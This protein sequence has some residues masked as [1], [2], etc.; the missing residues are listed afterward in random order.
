MGFIN[1][2]VNQGLKVWV[3][4][5]L[6]YKKEYLTNEYETTK[7]KNEKSCDVDNDLLTNYKEKVFDRIYYITET[8]N[9]II[10]SIF[11]CNHKFLDEK[12]INEFDNN[13]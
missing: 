11:K 6:K 12:L 10:K 1:S 3:F 5:N 13:L 8:H 7:I 2:L 9:E 4:A